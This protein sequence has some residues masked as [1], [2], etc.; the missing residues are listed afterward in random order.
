MVNIYKNYIKCMD[1]SELIIISRDDENYYISNTFI[2]LKVEP[3]SYD[4]FFTMEKPYYIPLEENTSVSYRSKSERKQ[5]PHIGDKVDFE[6]IFKAEPIGKAIKTPVKLELDNKEVNL[7]AIQDNSGEYIPLAV[8]V[9][10]IKAFDGIVDEWNGQGS[11]IA[12][13]CTENAVCLP[14]RVESDKA[15]TIVNLYV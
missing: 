14:V 15:K 5:K 4:T 1:K 2:A 3:L 9:D 10:Y 6:R 8:N 13:L 7:F 11:S 12:P